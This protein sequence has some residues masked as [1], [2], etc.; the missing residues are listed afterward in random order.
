MDL[1]FATATELVAALRSGELSSRDLLDH[2]L[3]RIDRMNPQL[4]AVVTVDVEGA[5]RAAA[6][7]DDATARKADLGAL[8]GLV[9]TIKDV[10]ETEGLRTTSGAS[11]GASP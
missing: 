6:A 8:H 7:A 1:S 3:K 2:V 5:R 10:W 9:M 11:S 4:N